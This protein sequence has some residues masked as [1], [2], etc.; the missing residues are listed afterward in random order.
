[1]LSAS[2]H[3]VVPRGLEITEVPLYI[4]IDSVGSNALLM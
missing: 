4:A 2:E 1:M 3:E